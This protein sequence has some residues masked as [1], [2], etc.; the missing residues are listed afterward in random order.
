MNHKRLY[1]MRGLPGS[2]KSHQARNIYLREVDR[3]EVHPDSGDVTIVSADDY[4]MVGEMLDR[5]EYIVEQ[6]DLAHKW[7]QGQ[8]AY[9]MR[10][11]SVVIVDNTNV[12]FA[13][14][15]PYLELA[16]RFSYEVIIVEPLTDWAFDVDECA[17]RNKHGVPLD[18]IKKM[19]QQ[20]QRIKISCE[21]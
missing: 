15:Q 10:H 8:T 3:L 11:N 16:A 18:I 12:S 9:Y 7:C 20:Y 19:A 17:K 5:Y 14:M 6:A 4:H 1:V 21:A 2:G 13:Q